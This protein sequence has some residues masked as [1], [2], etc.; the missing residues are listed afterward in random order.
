MCQ[1]LHAAKEKAGMQGMHGIVEWKWSNAWIASMAK[2]AYHH[3]QLS[4][5]NSK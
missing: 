5:G 3:E 1:R 2:Q 4:Q